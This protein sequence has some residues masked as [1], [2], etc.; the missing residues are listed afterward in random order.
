MLDRG[1]GLAAAKRQAATGGILPVAG[2]PPPRDR[3]GTLPGRVLRMWNVEN[4]PWS[5]SLCP[6]GPTVRKADP[7]PG[8]GWSKK[9]MPAAERQQDSVPSCAALLH[10]AARGNWPDTALCVGP[11][12]LLTWAR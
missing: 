1:A 11:E 8:T 5:G 6:G 2:T 3:G 7:R 9:P 12:G 4:P 10:T